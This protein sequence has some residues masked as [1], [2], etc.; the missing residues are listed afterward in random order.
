MDNP[1]PVY[2]FHKVVQRAYL[3]TSSWLRDQAEAR[4]YREL[5]YEE[6]KRVLE[7]TTLL[8]AAA[9]FHTYF[10]AHY[11]KVIHCLEQ[12]ISRP[13]LTEWLKHN[14]RIC[15]VDVGCGAGAASAA[16]IETVLRLQE[17]GEIDNSVQIY[18][19][20]VDPNAGAIALY[21]TLLGQLKKQLPHSGLD[22]VYDWHPVGIPRVTSQIIQSL[23]QIRR[24]WNIPNLPHVVVMQVNLVSPLDQDHIAQ[25]AKY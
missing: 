1:E 9:Q 25:Q 23:T 5:D 8:S 2:S 18:C 3:V 4:R 13:R 21:A 20:G 14:Q 6:V 16:F 19:L 17:S 10:P 22:L 12:V 7:E 24:E 11:F 15:V